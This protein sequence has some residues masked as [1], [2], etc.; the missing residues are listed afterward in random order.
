MLTAYQ[1]QTQRLLQYPAAPQP[2]YAIADVTD[3]IN[4]ARG[5]VASE[6]ECVRALGTLTTTIGQR[7]YN[8]TAIDIGVPAITG[9]QAV[10]HVRSMLYAVGGGFIPVYPKAWEWFSQFHL[11]TPI[12]QPGPPQIWAQYG[13][14]GAGLGTG[15]GA[16]GSLYID[17]P[18]DAAYVLTLDCVCYPIALTDDATIE[19]LPYPWTDAVPFFAAYFALLSAQT[20]ARDADAA[21]KFAAYQE[22]MSR[23]RRFSNPSQQ[24]PIYAQAQDPTLLAK[25]GMKQGPGG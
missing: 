13:Q 12:P 24:G 1:R 19:S 17:P 25:L 6:G 16:S 3:W 7:N 14:G 10:L 18:P 15:S 5:Q 2:L 4:I 8:F 23:A 11:G 22:F 9:R 21:R 20:G